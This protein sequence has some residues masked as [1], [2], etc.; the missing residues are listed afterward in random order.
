M[1]SLLHLREMH[2]RPFRREGRTMHTFLYFHPEADTP[3]VQRY[4]FGAYPNEPTRPYEIIMDLMSSEYV[5]PN[6]TIH[7][8][9]QLP[10]ESSPERGACFI[11]LFLNNEDPPD[12]TFFSDPIE[13]ISEFHVIVIG[14]FRDGNVRSIN[15]ENIQALLDY[16]A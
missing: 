2:L 9:H 10:N 12:R 13:P 16:F 15:D 1:V 3:F 8:L 14:I 4:A 5:A 7:S 11:L 6:A